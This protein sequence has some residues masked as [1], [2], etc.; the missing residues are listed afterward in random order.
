M[1]LGGPIAGRRRNLINKNLRLIWCRLSGKDWWLIWSMIRSFTV[2]VQSWGTT[3]SLAAV[4]KKKKKEF[5][6]P[7]SRSRH[8][9]QCK[10]M[11]KYWGLTGV[12]YL[13]NCPYLDVRFQHNY[14]QFINVFVGSW[15]KPIELRSTGIARPTRT[16]Y[17]LSHG[18]LQ[19]AA[20]SK[21]M[22]ALAF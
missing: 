16:G 17:G 22:V 15:P 11:I 19:A 18:V 10:R 21:T 12:G 4:K 9:Y 14:W 3:L 5:A 8:V 1:S 2:T 13:V 20:Y 6:R 7:Q